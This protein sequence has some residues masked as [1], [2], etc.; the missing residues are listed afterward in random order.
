MEP[1]DL[2]KH[3]PRSAWEK[4]DGLY[5]LPR[6]IDKIRGSLPGGNMGQYKISGFSALVFKE[7]DVDEDAFREAVAAADTDDDVIA[8]LRDHA[9]TARYEGVNQKLLRRTVGALSSQNPNY[10]DNY[11][12]AKG[13]PEDTVHFDILDK[14]DD[15]IFNPSY[16]E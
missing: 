9:D 12:M 4:L 14:D 5:M 16:S 8:W 2:T 1:L 3:R 6:T 11:P 13:V 7:L 15:T 10:F